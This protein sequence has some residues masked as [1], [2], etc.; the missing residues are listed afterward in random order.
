MIVPTG[1][2]SPMNDDF[3]LLGLEDMRDYYS[4]LVE[5]TPTRDIDDDRQCAH[6]KLSAYREFI[7]K[8]NGLI[9]R[10]DSNVE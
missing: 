7:N 3:L 2:E 8:L 6:A 4:E 1:Q 10:C 5:A 9:K